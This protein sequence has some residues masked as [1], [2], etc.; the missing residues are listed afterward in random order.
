MVCPVA[1]RRRC[2]MADTVRG[3]E[4]YYVTVPDAPG[5][6]QRILSALKERG[7]NL[8]AYLGFPLGGG[9]SQ[10]DLVPEDPESLKEVAQQAGI[11][12]SDAKRAFLIQGDDRV[13]AVADITAKLAEANINVTAAAATGAGSGRYGMILWVAQA[14][15]ER[16]AE[17][18]GA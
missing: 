15:Y 5:E 4:Y 6:G 18:L 14:D 16:A 13:G 7:V 10:I 2:A 11:T 3:V 1:A 12:L 17:A 9:R 8:L